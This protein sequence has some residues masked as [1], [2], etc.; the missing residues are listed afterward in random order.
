LINA[1]F[2]VNQNLE[3]VVLWEVSVDKLVLKN[4]LDC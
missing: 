4:T 3:V 2:V 1:I